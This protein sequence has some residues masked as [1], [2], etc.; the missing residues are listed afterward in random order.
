VR[1]PTVVTKCKVTACVSILAMMT[2]TVLDTA[3]IRGW[4]LLIAAY[5]LALCLRTAVQ[6]G[7][8]E[9]Q[10]Y[11]KRWSHQVFEDGFRSGVEQGREMEAAE[12]FIASTT[13]R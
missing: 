13:D 3:W 7:V 10:A 6:Q 9:T 11:I 12:R 8:A 5:A 1:I 2:G 4:A